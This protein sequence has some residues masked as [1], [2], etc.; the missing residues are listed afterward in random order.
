M[1]TIHDILKITTRNT[2][3]ARHR[4]GFTLVEL[5]IAV[6]ILGILAAVAVPSI[7]ATLPNRQLKVAA[8]DVFSTLQNARLLAVKRNSR[9]R[10]YFN[11][12]V[13]PGTVVIA[14]PDAAGNFT[15]AVDQQGE[16]QTN[17]STYGSG[18]DFGFPAGQVNWNGTAIANSVA[19]GGPDPFACTYNSDGTSNAGTVYL[20]NG[21]ASV[22]YAITTVTS[23]TVKLRKYN[24]ILPY[25]QNNWMD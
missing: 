8:R 13:N 21:Q 6:S 3:G 12:T 18:V 14:V 19:F 17:L 7:L 16:Y 11:N 10:V 20:Q 25:N 24:G 15:I 23:G 9:V 4:S 1:M 22:V 5:M 2:S